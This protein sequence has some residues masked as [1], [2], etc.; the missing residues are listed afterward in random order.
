MHK[1]RYYQDVVK[2]ISFINYNALIRTKRVVVILN[3]ARG[4]EI[5]MDNSK[6][7]PKMPNDPLLTSNSDEIIEM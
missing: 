2:Y 4:W 6:I 1:D 3:Q 7:R 5:C